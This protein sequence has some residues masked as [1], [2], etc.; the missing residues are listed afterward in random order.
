LQP[1]FTAMNSLPRVALAPL[2]VMWFG[3]GAL[4][5]VALAASLVFFVV[6][7]NTMAGIQGVDRDHLILARSLGATPTQTFLKF[8]LPSAIPSF[9]AGLELGKIYGFL[10]TV[11]GEMLAGEAGIGVRLQAYSGLFQTNEFFAAL[12]LLVLITT[13]ISIVLRAVRVRLLWWQA[14]GL[15]HDAR[16]REAH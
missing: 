5:K 6:L 16:G 8:I 3:I 2:F 7:L 1:F 15:G 9:F 12:L 14:L 10:G 4:S 11:A 13:T